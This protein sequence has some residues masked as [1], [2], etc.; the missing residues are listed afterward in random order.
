VDEP[1]S[2][3]L[4][5]FEGEKSLGKYFV[6]PHDNSSNFSFLAVHFSNGER[7]TKILVTHDGFLAEGKKDIS[8]GGTEDLV[9]LDDFIYS[10]PVEQ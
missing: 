3:S 8:D 10:E 4:E 6:P 2:A 5:F 9:V 1:N 7:I